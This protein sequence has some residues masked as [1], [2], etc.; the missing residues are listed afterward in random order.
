MFFKLYT[1]TKII[2]S[3]PMNLGDYNL[4]RGWDI[5]SDEDPLAP[6]YLVGY[7][8]AKGNFDGPLEGGCH[9]LSWSPK[10]V[11]EASYKENSGTFDFGEAVRR[12]EKGI[13]VMRTGWNGKNMYAVVMPGYPDGVPVNE[14]TAK[15]HKVPMGTILKFRPYW[16]LKTA[17]DDIT[18]WAPSGSDSLAKDWMEYKEV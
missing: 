2:K 15:I 14:V 16:V 6:G 9:H 12:A 7:P 1:G 13:R 3:L 17:Q 18:T 11:F 4:K 8:D 5:P 10:D